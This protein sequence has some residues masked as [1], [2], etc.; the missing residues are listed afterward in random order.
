MIALIAVSRF[1]PMKANYETKKRGKIMKNKLTKTSHITK[2]R[3]RV[4]LLLVLAASIIGL[5]PA[6]S[7]SARAGSGSYSVND[8]SGNY[9]WHAQGWDSGN[10]SV[11][12]D[13]LSAVGLITYTPATG[14]FHVDLIL[15][16]D[17]TTLHNLRDGT[18]T[19]D[20]NGHGTMTWLSGGGLT[21]HIDFYIVYGGAELKWIDTDP[22]TVELSTT[23]TM[24][25][26]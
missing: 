3:M 11:N 8:V 24:T 19:V 12:Y 26:Q 15:R 1:I 20:A 22:G 4:A 5:A 21:K 9:V 10:G 2:N 16:L 7:S 17:G 14:T 13:P 25:K 18:Y 23:G 6:F